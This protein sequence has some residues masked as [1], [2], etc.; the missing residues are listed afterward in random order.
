MAQIKTE[1][2][3]V[4]EEVIQPAD[5]SKQKQHTN[6]GG[7][8]GPGAQYTTNGTAGTNNNTA[9]GAQQQQKQ[10]ATGNT[11]GP[12]AQQ[13][14]RASGK[15]AHAKLVQT[16]PEFLAGFV[17]PDY[18]IDGLMQR[19]FFYA[20]TGMTGAGKTAVA[21][22][23]AVFVAMRTGKQ[24]LGRHEVEHGRV[25]YIAC[26]NSTDVRMRLI[27]MSERLSFDPADL[28]ILVIERFENGLKKDIPQIAKEIEAFG[29][30]VLVVVDTSAAVFPGDDE[31]NNPQALAHA[32]VQRTL[33]KL[34]G[35]PC[36]LSLC[37]PPK[38][39]SSQEQLLPRG[40]GAYVNE[41]DGNFTLFAR[42]DKLADFHWTGKF[43]GPDFDKITF[44]HSTV[45]TTKLTDTKGRLI[46]TVMA[47]VATE[48]DIE[49]SEEK[50]A[51]QENR[52]LRAMVDLPN[53]SI[54]EWAKRCGWML[55]AQ[56]GE[57]A[58]P[59]KSLTYRVLKR[60]IDAKLVK[61][62][63]RDHTITPAGTAAVNP[64]KVAS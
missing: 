52:L 20:I 43:R 16:L 31:N 35:G 58:K 8:A 40:G 23:I 62:N 18:L 2:L 45:T 6:G 38:N 30:V 41:T 39:V 63:G 28:D 15:A 13:K 11:T 44:Q 26:E 14:Q 64:S 42:D 12:G 37:H 50:A 10:G 46:P 22:L 49:E 27:G 56:P 54:A 32:K 9:G 51:L 57:E 59:N 48:A 4:D 3:R 34:P 24:F 60:L 29:P 5:A 21:L 19:G 7:A 47:Q 55:R 33:C 25:V 53:G 61:K 36:V 1:D 17:P